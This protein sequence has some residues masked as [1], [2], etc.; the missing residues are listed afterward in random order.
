MAD[1]ETETLVREANP[2]VPVEFAGCP[3][4][5]FSVLSFT[6]RSSGVFVGNAKYELDDAVLTQSYPVG[7]S[8]EFVNTEPVK[9]SVRFGRLLIIADR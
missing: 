5:K 4:A 8:N 7:V 9:V 6:E 1:G 2:P 3:G